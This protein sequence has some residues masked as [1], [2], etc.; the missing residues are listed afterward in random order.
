MALLHPFRALRPTP[1]SARDVASVPYDVVSRDEAAELAARNPLSFLHVSRPDIEFARSADPHGPDVYRVAVDNLAKLRQRAPLVVEEE[2]SLYAYRLRQGDQDQIGLA[3]CFSLDEYDQG[4]IKKHEHTRKDKEVDRTR[5][6]VALHAQTGLTFLTYRA[7][8]VVDV[9]VAG[10]A[11]AAPLID[12]EADDG[13]RHTIWRATPRQCAALVQAFRDVPALYIADGHHR[14][15][16]AD[17]ARMKLRRAAHHAAAELADHPGV[18]E[19]D[20]FVA[21]AFPHDVVRILPYNRVVRGLASRSG[22]AFLEA[23]R[24]VLPVTDGVAAPGGPGHVSMYLEGRWYDLLV[25]AGGDESTTL[26]VSRLQDLVIAPLLGIEDVRTDPRIDFI[27]G[28]RG[29]AE[30]ERR[31]D[32]GDASVGFSL[33][34]VGVEDLMDIADAGGIM[35]PKS[36]WFEPKVR[37]GLLSHVI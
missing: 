18:A 11:V 30:L 15:A 21:V 19:A 34:P 2:P 35:P 7:H 1:E 33:H 9:L 22:D 17:R 8:A 13:V 14:I 31:V 29:T 12:F 5:H 10:V 6:M 26:D 37:D 3:G 27:G 24:G 36:T 4:I 25:Q 32:S 16:S 20:T 23:L 28:A